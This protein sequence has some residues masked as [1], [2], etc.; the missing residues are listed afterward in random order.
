MASFKGSRSAALR[1]RVLPPQTSA[2][3]EQARLILSQNEVGLFLM[4]EGGDELAEARKRDRTNSIDYPLPGCIADVVCALCCGKEPFGS[5][6][7]L[8]QPEAA[9]G[10]PPPI[11][12]HPA[13]VDGQEHGP[14]LPGRG[15]HDAL[16]VAL[17]DKPVRGSQVRAGKISIQIIED[18]K[19]AALFHAGY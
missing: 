16:L 10:R 15:R 7:K 9:A 6:A 13:V 17:E 3:R 11:R 4:L 2:E 5:G 18:G 19:C 1:L 8:R 14:V 12:L